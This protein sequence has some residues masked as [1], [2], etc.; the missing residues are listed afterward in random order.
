MRLFFF[1]QAIILEWVAISSSRGIFP[2][3]GSNL[4]LRHFLHWQE[5]SLP[6]T[7]ALLGIYCLGVWWDLQM[8]LEAFLSCVK[9]C[10]KMLRT[11][12]E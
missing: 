1:F 3:K 4:C 5:D 7:N 9:H 12:Y 6:Q 2:I 10:I 11:C 8:L